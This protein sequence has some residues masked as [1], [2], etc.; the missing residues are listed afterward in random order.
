MIVS[1]LKSNLS[2][3]RRSCPTQ[4]SERFDFNEIAPLPTSVKSMTK[5]QRH[6]IE[7]DGSKF[8]CTLKTNQALLF[9]D[10]H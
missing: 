9:T 1:P 8:N 4:Q 5:L 3:G 6:E 2:I 7:I 10:Y